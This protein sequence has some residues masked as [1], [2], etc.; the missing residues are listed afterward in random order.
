MTSCVVGPL[1][2]SSIIWTKSVV[3][4]HSFV[5][6]L[7][8]QWGEVRAQT[9]TCRTNSDH[10][11]YW[12]YLIIA[13]IS[14]HYLIINVYL[15]FVP[16]QDSLWSIIWSGLAVLLRVS[17]GNVSVRYHLLSNTDTASSYWQTLP[18]I[19]PRLTRLLR[20]QYQPPWVSTWLDKMPQGLVWCERKI[21]IF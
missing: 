2:C 3:I 16:Y 6:A 10:A 5:W 4:R 7:C 18:T 11:L 19:F 12:K 21:L 17:V 9:Q 14:Q 1:F 8:Q 13:I 20:Y 15:K